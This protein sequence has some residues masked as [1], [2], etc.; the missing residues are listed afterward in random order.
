MIIPNIVCGCQD[1]KYLNMANNA[2]NLGLFY[3]I[4][5]PVTILITYPTQPLLHAFKKY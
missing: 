5:I 4:L 2:Y 3:H 1:Y